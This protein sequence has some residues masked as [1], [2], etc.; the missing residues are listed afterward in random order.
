MTQ[1]HEYPPEVKAQALAMLVTGRTIGGTA[2]ELG[3]PRPT[4]KRWWRQSGLAEGTATFD[5]EQREA[6]AGQVRDYAKTTLDSLTA[7]AEHFAD[8]EWL[9]GQRAGELAILHGVTFDKMFNTL[10]R[11]HAGDAEPAADRDG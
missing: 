10:A 8:Q 5:E 3:I 6:I 4:V 11:L 2:K 9:R 7:Q 1:Q